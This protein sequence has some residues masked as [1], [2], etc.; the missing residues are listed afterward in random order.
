V[1]HVAVDLVAEF[2]G[3][4][5]RGDWCWLLMALGDS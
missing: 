5:R 1:V 4:R 3:R 2:G